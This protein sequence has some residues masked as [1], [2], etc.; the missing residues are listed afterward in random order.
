M[1]KVT[2]TGAD[3]SIDPRELIDLTKQFPFVEWGILVSSSRQGVSRFPSNRW[4]ARLYETLRDWPHMAL[5]FHICGAWVREICAGNWMPLFTNMGPILH[6]G[7][8]IQLNFHAYE[9]LLTKTFIQ[10]ALERSREQ[11]WQLIFQCDGVNDHLVSNAHDDGLN[12]VPLYDK[13]GGAGVVPAEWPPPMAGIYSGYA[14]GLGPE[15]LGIEIP[16]I[17]MVTRGEPYWI[18]METNVRSVRDRQF[19]LG[20]VHRCLEISSQFVSPPTEREAEA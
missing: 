9:H 20:K 12:V 8:R 17:E 16:R 14:G 13:S 18:D 15:N 7:K 1:E 4:L 2:I 6:C 10:A 11:D 5:S 3:D 19:D